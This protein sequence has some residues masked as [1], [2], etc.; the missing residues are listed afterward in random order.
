MYLDKSLELKD[1]LIAYLNIINLS[2]D[3]VVFYTHRS[4]LHDEIGK[5]LGLRMYNE[6]DVLLLEGVL[7]NLDKEIEYIIGVEYNEKEIEKMA[8]K[9]EE[10]LKKIMK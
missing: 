3:K 7:H 9:L 2:E 1:L 5:R 8:K 10:R 4:D 6:Y